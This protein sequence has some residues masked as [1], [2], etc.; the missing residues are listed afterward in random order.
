MDLTGF[1]DI[2]TPVG[3]FLKE[4]GIRGGG[5]TE[6]ILSNRGTRMEKIDSKVSIISLDGRRNV[7]DCGNV[8]G[9]RYSKDWQDDGFVFLVNVNFQLFD[10][11]FSGKLSR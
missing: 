6:S 4:G 11:R 8:E 1:L 10:F 5:I 3:Q 9:D 7:F 2:G